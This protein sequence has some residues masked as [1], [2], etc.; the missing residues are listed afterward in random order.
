MAKCLIFLVKLSYADITSA[1]YTGN[2]FVLMR[3][4]YS[5]RCYVIPWW[6]CTRHSKLKQLTVG[7]RKSH[8]PC[9]IC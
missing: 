2:C 8:M 9:I 1:L 4:P 6:H 5:C 7:N 3:R